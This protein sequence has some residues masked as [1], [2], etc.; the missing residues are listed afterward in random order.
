MEMKQL[1]HHPLEVTLTYNGHVSLVWLPSP[2][3]A[4][5]G[6]PNALSWVKAGGYLPVPR[7]PTLPSSPGAAT[8][9]SHD[10]RSAGGMLSL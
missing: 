4:L 5:S 8:G 6:L 7:G 2:G 1:L 3:S 10:I 9:P